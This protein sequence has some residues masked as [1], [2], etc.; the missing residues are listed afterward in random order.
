MSP[1]I[2]IL[3]AFLLCVATTI[4]LRFL[5]GKK[6]DIYFRRSPPKSFITLRSQVSMHLALGYPVTKE[7]FLISLALVLVLI[8]EIFLVA[9]LF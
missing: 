5:L 3:I 9:F 4:A 8:G 7:G 1:V 2:K 6:R